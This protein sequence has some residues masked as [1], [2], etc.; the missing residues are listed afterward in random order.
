MDITLAKLGHYLTC[1]CGTNMLNNWYKRTSYCRLKLVSLAKVSCIWGFLLCIKG[2]HA[3][4][5]DIPAQVR[6]PLILLLS[7]DICVLASPLP[8]SDH[9]AWAHWP[10]GQ[11]AFLVLFIRGR[12][13]FIAPGNSS[14]PRRHRAIK[15]AEAQKRFYIVFPLASSKR[16][17]HS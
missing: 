15:S 8:I 11:S 2:S 14:R 3:F 1:Q 17:P 16:P 4:Y 10:R 9:L 7:F 13:S 6:F 12:H 5:Y